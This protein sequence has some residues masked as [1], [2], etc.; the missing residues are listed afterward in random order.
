[1]TVHTHTCAAIGCQHVIASGLLM[2]MDHWRMVPAPLRREVLATNRMRRLQPGSLVALGD[3]RDAVAR[4]V[5]AV[6]EK[7][8]RKATNGP[9]GNLFS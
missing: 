9:S 5:A 7:Q 3:Y 4:A 8:E 1:M 2:C 6:E